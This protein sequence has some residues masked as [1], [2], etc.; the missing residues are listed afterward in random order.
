VL[1]KAETC[2]TQ[3]PHYAFSIIL[4][5]VSLICYVSN[6]IFL[7]VSTITSFYFLRRRFQSKA[8]ASFKLSQMLLCI[9]CELQT[10]I[11]SYKQ[12]VVILNLLA[13]L[14]SPMNYFGTEAES[15]E[16]VPLPTI[17]CEYKLCP[18]LLDSKNNC[19]MQNFSFLFPI[20]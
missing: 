13:F 4:L 6:N 15:R 3:H 14:N 12:F 9:F 2:L 7:H 8:S 1:N 10:V 5:N 17:R 19:P 16:T 20:Y 18:V 11:N